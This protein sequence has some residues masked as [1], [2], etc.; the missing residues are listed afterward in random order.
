MVA[1]DDDV[2]VGLGFRLMAHVAVGLRMSTN[3]APKDESGPMM[4]RLDS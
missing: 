1:Q 2:D 4:Q 3:P